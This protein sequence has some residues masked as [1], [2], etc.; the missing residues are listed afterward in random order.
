MSTKSVH[1]VLKSY[2][3]RKRKAG[4]PVSVSDAVQAIRIDLPKCE[5]EDDELA[6]I[7]TIA[8]IERGLGVAFDRDRM[9]EEMSRTRH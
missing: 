2:L 1:Q 5:L 8:A 3:E 6:Q 7:V 4:W 9:G